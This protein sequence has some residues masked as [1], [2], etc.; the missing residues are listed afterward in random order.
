MS[1]ERL[2]K[3]AAAFVN[4]GVLPKIAEEVERTIPPTSHDD[5]EQAVEIMQ[6]EVVRFFAEAAT[7]EMLVARI[8]N[9][10][11]QNYLRLRLTQ[12]VHSARLARLEERHT[13]D[14]DAALEALPINGEEPVDFETVFWRLMGEHY[15][16]TEEERS[17]I[18][19]KIS[20]EPPM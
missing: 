10:P 3:L 6:Q 4:L 2:K 7:L 15:G 18:I 1:A 19:K 20:G 14:L 5:L 9:L 13:T 8:P 11:T 12:Q 17:K 16:V